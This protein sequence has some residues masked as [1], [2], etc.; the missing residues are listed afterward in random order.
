[1]VIFWTTFGAILGTILGPDRPKVSIFLVHPTT[2]TK[3]QQLHQRFENLHP[4][5]IN[6]ADGLKKS[7][8]GLF[9]YV[10]L[11]S[12]QTPLFEPAGPK[13]AQDAEDLQTFSKPSPTLLQTLL[14]TPSEHLEMAT[15]LLSRAG[16]MRG[17][18]E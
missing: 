4:C 8:D 17:A 7:I 3:A 15:F 2:A 5:L 12:L 14:Q 18:I 11:N 9:R 16:G 6:L 13:M 1:M 10:W